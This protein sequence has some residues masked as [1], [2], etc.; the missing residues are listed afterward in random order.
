MAEIQKIV[1]AVGL[2]RYAE[3]VYNHAAKLAIAFN[4]QLTVVNV[5]NSRDIE[6]IGSVI[7]LGYEVDG[8]HYVTE[9]K[10]RREKEIAEIIAKS[11]QPLDSVNVMVTSGNPVDK[12]LEITIMEKA[13]MIVMGPKGKT[14]LE[15]M[16]IGSVA[17][18]L[19]RSS[20]ITVV[21]YR[22]GENTARLRKHLHIK[23]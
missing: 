12:L 1:V 11:D 7:A 8:D 19:F 3:G 9:V 21:S 15:H 4:A 18:K 14:D 13:D 6:A 5:I 16:F 2:G 17:S 22:D 10:K 20:P 23:E